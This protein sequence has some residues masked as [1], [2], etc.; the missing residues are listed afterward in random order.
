MPHININIE[1]NTG[2]EYTGGESVVFIPGGILIQ[3]G[4]ADTNK[5]TYISTSQ[6]GNLNEILSIN[7]TNDET[8]V[9]IA[10][11]VALIEACLVNNLDVIY[12]YVDDYGTKVN[13][14]GTV[15]E[16]EGDP[17]LPEIPKLL[18]GTVFSGELIMEE[19][20]K[21]KQ[22]GYKPN[23]D[24]LKDKDTY[25]V[26]LLTTG[27]FGVQLTG[28][29]DDS[30]PSLQDRNEKKY[31]PDFDTCL[32]P[33]IELADFRKDCRVI[34]G[35][36]YY[37][38]ESIPKISGNK[39]IRTKDPTDGDGLAYQ[40]STYLE[41]N[42]LDHGEYGALY[43]PN[44]T[45]TITLN[46]VSSLDSRT[47]TLTM[48]SIYGYL[49]DY[50]KSLAKG[51]EWLPV[52]NSERGSVSTIGTADLTVTKYNLDTNIIKDTNGTSFN[53]IVN[54]RPYG[55]VIWGDRTLLNLG[56]TV[57]ATAYLS[58]SLL[59]CDVAKRAYQAA[60]RYTYESNNDVTWFNFKTRVTSLLDEMVAAGVLG[61]YK[62]QK[63]P[64][65]TYNKIT[66]KITLYPNL[67]VENFDIYINLENAD[68]STS[69][70]EE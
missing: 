11:T 54:L 58:L 49:I 2:V 23:I 3:D 47:I 59:I 32:K 26:K 55:D 67:P 69:G 57:K 68:I 29:E 14:Y 52:A 43:L 19:K 44:I 13:K 36:D 24:F 35:F 42:P 66:C 62:M 7:I 6:Y 10:G 48:P 60:V 25:N 4:Y 21:K 34:S 12:C 45:S 22:Y 20:T 16:A 8:A 46:S 17:K 65:K 28:A 38:D 18:P 51:Q 30:L 1:D 40:I 39:A 9:D 33:L 41:E 37:N 31:T 70:G 15:G 63:Q 56:D 5:C 53:G 27:Y 50:G 64:S 61:N